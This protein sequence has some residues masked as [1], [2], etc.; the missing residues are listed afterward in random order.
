MSEWHRMVRSTLPPEEKTALRQ[1]LLAYC[2]M[3]TL[4]MVELLHVLQIID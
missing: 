1:H 2:K 3:D 4:A